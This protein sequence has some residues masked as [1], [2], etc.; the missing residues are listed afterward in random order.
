MKVYWSHDVPCATETKRCV[1][2]IS[3]DKGATMQASEALRLFGITL[4]GATPE[5][6]RKLLLTI[7]LIVMVLL[8]ATIGRRLLAGTVGQRVPI[9]RFLLGGLE[10]AREVGLQLGRKCLLSIQRGH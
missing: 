3:S 1:N 9:N 7:I 5:N 4:V 2:R 6:G 8:F 10:D